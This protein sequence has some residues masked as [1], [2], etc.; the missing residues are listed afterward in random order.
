MREGRPG[1]AWAEPAAIGRQRGASCGAASGCTRTHPGCIQAA[2]V[3]TQAAALLDVRGLREE[4]RQGLGKDVGVAHD[5]AGERAGTQPAH[6]G[7]R[8]GAPPDA[9]AGQRDGDGDGVRHEGRRL[10]G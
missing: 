3:R 4:L 10:G 7:R 9:R 2:S 8:S 1:L 5:Q 6:R